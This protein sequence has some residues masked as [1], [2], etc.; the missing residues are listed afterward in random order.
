MNVSTFVWHEN[1]TF[2]IENSLFP[3]S[4]VPKCDKMTLRVFYEDKTWITT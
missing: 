4:Y 2:N 1:S 3:F